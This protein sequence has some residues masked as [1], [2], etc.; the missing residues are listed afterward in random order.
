[1]GTDDYG[2]NTTPDDLAPILSGKL[3]PSCAARLR[4]AEQA[5]AFA[6]AVATSPIL[7]QLEV[8]DLSLGAL[9][10]AGAE[11]LLSSPALSKLKRL[12]LHQNYLDDATRKKVKALGIECDVDRG[13]AE[14]ED[15]GDGEVYRYISLTE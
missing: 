11:A 7:E 1:M 13:D 14:E 5:D 3:F 2:G 15:Y 6:Q 12:N 4:N 10:S 8:L 9:T